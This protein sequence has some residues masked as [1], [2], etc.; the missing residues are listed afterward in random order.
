[1]KNR[2]TNFLDR[3]FFNNKF[4]MVF[5][6]LLAIVLWAVVKVNSSETS[7]RVLTDVKVNLDT[8]LAQENDY[9]AFYDSDSLS[10]NVE[11]SGSS[12][13]I[14]TYSLK[15]DNISVEATAGYVDS[16]G[17]KT[18][19]L[20]A[21]ADN[22]DVDVV[23]ITPSSI[24]VF[25]DRSD[26]QTFNVEARLTNTESQLANNGYIIGQPIPSVSTVDV[27]GPATVLDKITK[28]YFDATLDESQLP[29][30]ATTEVSATIAYDL[31]HERETGFLVCEDLDSGSN[32]ATVTIPVNRE[33]TV[34]TTVKFINQPAYF[35]ENPPA[36]TI[37][38]AK[39]KI[40]LNAEDDSEELSSFNVGTV[41]F[42]TLK[43]E[44]N[45]L[46]FAPD[47]KNTQLIDDVSKFRVEIDLSSLSSVKLDATTSNVV[48]LNQ[49][50]DYKYEA[51]LENVGL[52]QVTIVGPAA[53]LKKLHAEDLQ[54]AINV[55]S[56][57]K[58]SSTAHA[59]KITNISIQ[60]SDINDCWVYGTYRA[61]VRMTKKG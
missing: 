18:L 39:V 21:H 23:K 16:A 30:T 44:V 41:D 46:S 32:T 45:T 57:A 50:A 29:L 2:K 60:P 11:V 54:I 13:N 61:R 27:T 12:Y 35:D 17:Y 22:S 42:H 25:F 5:S 6:V 3:L 59:V 24:T 15:R 43:N 47:K 1:M 56:I 19:N 37:S 48:F 34:E 4:L 58:A 49:S 52:D 26:T 38:P 40:S 8:S 33:A 51:L 10:V 36:V 14:N 28:V 20:S 53:S 55:S 31:E 7:T 9:I